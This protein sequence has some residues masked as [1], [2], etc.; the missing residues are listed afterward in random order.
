[1]KCDT[2]SAVTSQP[3]WQIMIVIAIP[4]IGSPKGKPRATAT[5]PT[6]GPNDEMA[7]SHEWRASSTGV[8]DW[9][10]TRPLD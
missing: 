9:M 1:M 6:R 8:A 2:I 4:A 5:R 10:R 3:T 7:S